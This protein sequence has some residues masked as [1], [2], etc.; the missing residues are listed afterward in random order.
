[1]MRRHPFPALLVFFAYFAVNWGVARA[2]APSERELSAARAEFGAGVDFA[3]SGDW[4]RAVL[5]FRR[6]VEVM[7]APPVRFN[8]ASA[9]VELGHYPEAE[10]LLEGIAR[11]AQS[12]PEL[13]EASEARLTQL[14]AE[15]GRVAF[16]SN[17]AEAVLVDGYA[18][19][20]EAFERG[21][22]VN[23]GPH[24][25]EAYRDGQIVSRRRIEVLEGRELRVAFTESGAA[26][27]IDLASAHPSNGD[28]AGAT[29]ARGRPA[30]LRNKWVWIGASAAVILVVGASV[31]VAVRNSR[32]YDGNFE[33]GRLRW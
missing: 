19:G 15:G 33:P 20:P 21:V 29:G 13:R 11:D 3:D 9:L 23:V 22:L 1:M 12:S 6:V 25:V 17:T 32:P 26:R 10:L 8:L 30:W 4:E 5:A 16:E 7:P 14:R 27:E 28:E 18:I 2:Q 31:G 24:V